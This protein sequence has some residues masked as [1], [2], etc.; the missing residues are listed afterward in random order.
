M[1]DKVKIGFVG[2][3]GIANSHLGRL[4]EIEAAQIVALCDVA[5]ERVQEASRRWGGKTYTDY[6]QM[7]ETE[8]LDALYVC[9]PPFA[10]ENA[11]ILAAQKG[12]HLFVEKPVVLDLELGVRIKEV[13]EKAGIITSVG[14]GMR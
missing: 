14:Y 10:H 2:T 6:R 12:I 4:A 3:G 13:V 1:P 5:E 8:T 11:E 7:L 9:I